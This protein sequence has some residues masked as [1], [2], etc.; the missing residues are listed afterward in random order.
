MRKLFI[1]SLGKGRIGR[2]LV[3]SVILF[4]SFVTLIVSLYQ[5]YFDYK[6]DIN[7]IHGYFSL[8]QTSYI[9]NLSTNVWLYDT[10]QIKSQ[11]D[12]LIKLPDLE[13][14]EIVADD[15]HRWSSGVQT[16]SRTITREFPLNFTHKDQDFSIG[17]LKVTTSLDNVYH[18]LTRKAVSIII[19]NAIRA[20]CVSGFILFIFHYLV[21]R[22]LF[23]LANLLSD[24][25]LEQFPRRIS[26]GRKKGK[27][28]DEIDL[29]VTAIKESQ[30][31]LHASYDALVKSEKELQC[32]FSLSIDMICIAD[33]NTQTFTK[34]NPAFTK[35]LGFSEEELTTRPFIEFVHPDDIEPTQK[36]IEEK[37]KAG[38]DV[39]NFQNR[40][41][42][43]DGTY[44]W[45]RWVSNPVIDNGVTYALAH[46][47][48]DIK[49][50]IDELE[51]AHQR[52]L[53][54]LDAIDAHVYVADMETYNILFMNEKMKKDFGKDLTGDSCW[55]GFRGESGPCDYCTNEKLLDAQGKP[56]DVCV[57]QGENPITEKWYMNYDRAIEWVDG[58]IV[59]MQIAMD[60]TEQ[61]NMEE[62][63]RQSHK[64]EAV[65]TLAGGIAHDFNNILGIIIGNTELALDDVP[66]WNPARANLDEI[67]LA[68]LRAKDVVQ[69]L[70]SF[71]RKTEQE[72]KPMETAP[73]VTESMRL[74]R[75]SIPAT[76]KIQTDIDEDPGIIN[77]N[78]TQIQQVIINLCTN[79]AHAMEQTGGRL[80]VRLKQVKIETDEYDM[81]LGRYLQLRVSDTGPGIDAKIKD[82]IFDPYF[83]TKEVGKGSGMGLAIVHG[84][85]TN[86]DGYIFAESLPGKG[87]AF[88]VFFPIFD[89]EI[90][91]RENMANALPGGNERILFVD[92][93]APIVR[94]TT[95]MLGR[96]GYRVESE[97]NPVKALEL[98]KSD[99]GS[100]DL[101]ITDM[102]MPEM[103]GSDLSKQLK[104]IRPDIPI[105]ICTGF[106]SLVGE[107]ESRKLG[108]S[109]FIMKPI[110][111]GEI[112]KTIRLVLDGAV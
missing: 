12:G 36:V 83:T 42:C 59:R 69:Q 48:T 21:T 91:S 106:S 53:T 40:Y 71:S 103:N 112:A 19:T 68:G 77:A 109:S 63:L 43:K 24:L 86:H 2:R 65:G 49:E 5:L 107:K 30:E 56:A 34:V 99:P 105:I 82:K 74:L 60:I 3:V 72:R 93:E 55:L 6:Q 11:L 31:K 73:L 101:V 54:V 92:D 75:A 85:V 32:I 47:I 14:I 110:E 28:P 102:T 44:K 62:K 108:V 41:L 88:N 16:S 78:P 37:L 57:W 61:K 22:H 81:P 10:Q 25:D 97:Q 45:L 27:V 17:V 76:I 50:S 38:E 39:I 18:R 23:R 33:I 58:R 79:A 29:V 96:L 8:I 67:K 46:D 4:S 26:L 111:K 15:N 52:F 20:F 35:T 84:I 80:N 100:F 89:S 98:F 94:M 70:L 87:T 95:Q 104:A 66:E 51:V 9:D 90:K 1:N 13:Y 64:M 7:K